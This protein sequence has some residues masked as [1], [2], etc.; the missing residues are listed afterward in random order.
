LVEAN[1][2]PNQHHSRWLKFVRGL[3]SM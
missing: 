1:P 2:S 3:R